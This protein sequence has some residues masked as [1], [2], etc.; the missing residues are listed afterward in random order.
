MCRQMSGARAQLTEKQTK[1]ANGKANTHQAESRANPCQKSSLCGQVDARVLFGG[2]I[3][4]AIVVK[5]ALWM[6]GSAI[7][8]VYVHNTALRDER[9]SLI[10]RL[11]A[12]RS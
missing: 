7:D 6:N 2:I 4:T 12:P 3:H 10:T 8:Y 9:F 1:A 5:S 11:P